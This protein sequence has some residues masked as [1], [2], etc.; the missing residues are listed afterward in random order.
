VT[1]VG[2]LKNC[3]IFTYLLSILE[4]G[5]TDPES[6]DEEADARIGATLTDTVT[7][8][9]HM[10]E[11][12]DQIAGVNT[13]TIELAPGED[14]PHASIYTNPDVP[15]LA[16]PDC[17]AGQD[18][19]HWIKKSEAGIKEP[20]DDM[21]QST[22]ILKRLSSHFQTGLLDKTFTT[23]LRSLKLASKNLMMM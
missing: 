5:W 13:R 8:P 19:H 3:S 4:S 2:R 1:F 17:F 15:F 14:R 21:F 12:I 16:F 18:L 20:D 6:D 22:P 7:C 10:I 23:G 11:D 9:D